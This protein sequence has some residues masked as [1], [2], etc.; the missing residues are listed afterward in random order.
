MPGLFNRLIAPPRRGHAAL[1]AG[2]MVASA[3]TESFGIMLL[4]PV[5]TSLDGKGQGPFGQALA[6]LGIELPLGGLL[7]LMVA[8]V[9]VRALVNLARNRAALALELGVV[10]DLRRRAWRALLGAEW[11]ILLGLSKAES[12]S[13]LITDIDRA[14]QALNQAIGVAATLVT[15]GG[16][17][18]AGL[19][20]APE[21]TL[22]GGLAGLAVMLAYR[23]MRQRA[24]TLGESVGQAH[25][26]MHGSLSDSLGAL[27]TVKSLGDEARAEAQAL[28]GQSQ[29]K[30]A[31]L[32][33]QR[34]L[35]LGQLA[36]QFGG[37]AALAAM[38]WLAVTVWGL[39]MSSV[40]PMAA[41]FAR[42]VPLLGVLQECTQNYAHAQP[43]MTAAFDLIDRAELAREPD[44]PLADPPRPKRTIALRTA[45]VQYA[46]SPR[47]AIDGVSLELPVGS[48]TALTG[49]SGAG[50]S[51]LADVLGGL[52]MPNSGT[53]E[54]DGV[55]LDRAQ[56][57]AWRSQVAY[58]QQDPAILAATLRDN[59]LWAA[60]G[61]TETALARALDQAACQFVR[62]WP[63][64]LETRIGDGGRVLSGGE[65]QRLMLARAL[66]R[67]PRLLILDEGTSAL[68]RENER[69]V[70]EALAPLRG[71]MTILI[72]AHRGMLTDLADRTCRLEQGRLVS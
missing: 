11:R 9:L 29:L 66:L 68:D 28:S 4:V 20:V 69:L 52:I 42:V 63:E 31:Q 58:V 35:T 50:K 65:R 48:V 39:G 19:A 5:V 70:A 36:L 51:T 1:L 54:I 13:L 67:R 23:R 57:R 22:T 34:D 15:L 14:G 46:A 41:L 47:A 12:A 33:Y 16:L 2:L 72:I 24:V 25:R 40:L 37:A 17:A 10:E 7:L 3:L 59:L 8:L 62:D 71:T 30:Q 27:R 64:G 55:P 61:A 18:I 60:P 49:P 38:V 56:T 44:L 53:L 6:R 21:L 43:A 45:S 32:A 26:E